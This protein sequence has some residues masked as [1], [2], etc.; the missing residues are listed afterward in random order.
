ER[1]EHLARIAD[2]VAVAVA[3]ERLRGREQFGQGR[4]FVVGEQMLRL[5]IEH[6]REIS[7]GQRPVMR[8]HRR[9]SKFRA[10]IAAASARRIG[11]ASAGYPRAPWTGAS[12]WPA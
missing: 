7:G 4:T 10:L 9:V 6:H 5:R 11:R 1:D 3:P 8:I 12:K 2:D